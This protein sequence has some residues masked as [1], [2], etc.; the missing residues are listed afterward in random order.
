MRTL[1]IGMEV[2]RAAPFCRGHGLHVCRDQKALRGASLVIQW[3]DIQSSVVNS[4]EDLCSVVPFPAYGVETLKSLTRMTN[5][6]WRRD[7]FVQMALWCSN[8]A[9]AHL[10]LLYR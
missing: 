8:W 4:R 10:L 2:I 7:S 5:G 3:D 6:R 1:V 9:A